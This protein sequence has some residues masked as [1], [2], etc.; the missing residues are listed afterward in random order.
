MLLNILQIGKIYL[1]QNTAYIIIILSLLTCQEFIKAS[2]GIFAI[3]RR[4]SSIFLTTFFSK[5]KEPSVFIIGG[6]L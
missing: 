5:R 4:F 3:F 1:R 6:S 2:E